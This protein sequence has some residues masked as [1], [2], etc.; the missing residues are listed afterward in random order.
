MA[1]NAELPDLLARFESEAQKLNRKSDSINAILKGIE[2][3]L[4]KA[5]AGVE[6]WLRD[7]DQLLWSIVKIEDPPSTG[8]SLHKRE[9]GFT[10]LDSGGWGLAVREMLHPQEGDI[11]DYGEDE[12]IRYGNPVCVSVTP[13]LQASREYRLKALE[14]MPELL[15]QL[16]AAVAAAC[17][18]IDTAARKYPN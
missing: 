17:T 9:M 10:K 5:N 8:S 16:A 13:L 2:Q 6:A 12:D 14:L 4:I 1:E 18:A 7:P 15:K 3:R 11:L